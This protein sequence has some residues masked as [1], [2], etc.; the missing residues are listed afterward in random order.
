MN[1]ECK[2]S[3]QNFKLLN[4]SIRTSTLVS[5][6]LNLQ[7]P[8][9]IRIQSSMLSTRPMPCF[10]SKNIPYYYL[11][12]DS[13]VNVVRMYEC[14]CFVVLK[15]VGK[16]TGSVFSSC[17]YACILRWNRKLKEKGLRTY[18]SKCKMMNPYLI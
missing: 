17:R 9:L 2:N 6:V 10:I 18:P 8:L 16:F 7:S 1:A 12:V 3:H 13:P 15:S 11:C 5:W 14:G 4:Y